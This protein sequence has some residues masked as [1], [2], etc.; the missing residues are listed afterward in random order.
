[1]CLADSLPGQALALSDRQIVHFHHDGRAEVRLDQALLHRLA[2]ALL[3][4]GRVDVP[5]RTSW[6]RV[7]L[8]SD[9]DVSLLESL[10]S[11]AIKAN[12]PSLPRPL[13]LCPHAALARRRS[14]RLS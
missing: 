10:V 9:S 7:L 1:M 11:L 5:P 2:P 13:G 12:D 4:S 8:D 6:V 3:A 14:P